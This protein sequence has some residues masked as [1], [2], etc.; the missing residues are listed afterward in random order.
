[1]VILLDRKNGTE[2][3]MGLLGKINSFLKFDEVDTR[4]E[5]LEREKGS[6]VQLEGW[7]DV[8]PQGVD[9]AVPIPESIDEVEKTLRQIFRS[10]INTDVIYRRFNIGDEPA[11]LV[12]M[13]GMASSDNISRFILAP[14]MEA[15]PK[16]GLTPDYVVNK[17]IHLSETEQTED[18]TKVKLS[19][20]DGM[21]VLFAGEK[22]FALLLDTRGYEKRSVSTSENEKVVRGPQEGFTESLRTNIT[23]L[24][25]IIRSDDLVVEYRLGGGDNNTRIAIVYRE[26]IANRTL[27]SE[28]K[29]R[30]SKINVRMLLST[31]VIEQLI[32]DSTWSPLPQVL[33]TERPDRV[34]SYVMNGGAA[35]IAD[36]S[37]F[38]IVMP[39]T[40]STLMSTPEDIYTRQPLGTVMRVVRYAGAIL[41]LMLPAYFIALAL[42]HQGLLSTEVLSTVIQSRKMV[43]E[44]LPFEMLL[45][46]FVFQ[47]IREAGM[48]V[49]GSIGQAIGVIGGLILGQAAV[50]ANLASSV[51]LIIV[52]LSGL[53]N[54]C[55]P[56]YSTQIAASY[57]RIA[58]VIAAWMGGLLGLV[59]A[60]MLFVGYAANLKSFGVPFLS[61]FAPKTY[62]KRPMVIRGKI[63]MHHRAEDYINAFSDTLE[64]RRDGLE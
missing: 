27:I 45:L 61:P 29:R 35:V 42:Y 44:P 32:E 19:I 10:D 62:S 3:R 59:A 23:L 18:L 22:P 53:G 40:I 52:A 60:F 30:L 1:M 24:R 8:Y 15:E 56:D 34:S 55:I 63:K 46:L 49:P 13:N 33:S 17:V 38:A 57:F 36:G 21:T 48:R 47:L 14:A 41:S 39:I 64:K 25:R 51:I 54:F 20:M 16:E 37:P 2:T 26:G 50:A 31:G 12:F 6:P 4:Y 28:V 9:E 11:M 58:F 43:F 5:L 7:E